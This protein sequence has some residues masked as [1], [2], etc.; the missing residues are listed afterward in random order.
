MDI[1]KGPPASVRAANVAEKTAHNRTVYA[2]RLWRCGVT[3]G[4]DIP[5]RTIPTPATTQIFAVAATHRVPATAKTSYTAGTLYAI[6]LKFSEKNHWHITSG[7]V[8][9]VLQNWF[10]VFFRKVLSFVGISNENL[11]ILRDTYWYYKLY[12]SASLRK[13]PIYALNLLKNNI[14][15]KNNKRFESYKCVT[16]GDFTDISRTEVETNNYETRLI[17]GKYCSVAQGVSFLLGVEHITNFNTTYGFACIKSYRHIKSGRTKGDIVIGNDVWI[18]SGVKILS[19]VKIGDGAVIGANSLVT[20]DVPGYAI[21]GGNP[22][23]L[24]RMRFP[25][26]IIKTFEAIKWWDWPLEDIN[27]TI[28]ILQSADITALKTYYDENIVKQKNGV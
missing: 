18:G 4:L 16:A 13:D 19:G 5:L 27:K 6:F 25:E 20:K 9:A 2:P 24:I 21:Y 3:A 10:S 23:K 11:K 17:V 8:M 22:A 14:H 26:E 12:G 28:P 1:T 7:G 15:K